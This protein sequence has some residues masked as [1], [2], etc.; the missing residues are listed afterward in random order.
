MALT[1]TLPTAAVL[2][3]AAAHGPP[4]D[5]LVLALASSLQV[6]ARLA[7]AGDPAGA[8]EALLAVAA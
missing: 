3:V 1:T 5:D 7:L 6:A 4:C 8:L 2:A